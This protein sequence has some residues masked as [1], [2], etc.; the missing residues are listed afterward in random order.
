MHSKVRDYDTCVAQIMGL[1][2]LSLSPQHDL[3]CCFLNNHLVL[4]LR[5]MMSFWTSEIAKSCTGW[6]A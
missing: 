5:H 6:Y 1:C 3:K 2:C 4:K